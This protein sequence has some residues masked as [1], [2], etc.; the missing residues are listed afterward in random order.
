M[1]PNGHH[2]VLYLNNSFGFAPHFQTKAKARSGSDGFGNNQLDFLNTQNS[3]VTT[4]DGCGLKEC[5][6]QNEK[7]GLAEPT[8]SMRKGCCEARFDTELEKSKTMFFILFII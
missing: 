7:R 5:I 6:D 8:T 2:L 1:V 4:H 3:Q